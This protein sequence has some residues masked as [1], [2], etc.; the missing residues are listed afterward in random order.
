MR[1]D[2]DWQ[3]ALTWMILP[4]GRTWYRAVSKAFVDFGMSFST[5]APILAIA[6]LGE[7]LHQNIIADAIGVD[8]AALARSVDQLQSLGL[9]ERRMDLGDRRGRTLHL[10]E[11]GRSLAGELGV[12]AEN[13]QR[14]ALK[15]VKAADGKAAVRAMRCLERASDEILRA[16]EKR[17]E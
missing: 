4:V 10:T 6:K 7:G 16:K 1:S 12:V 17:E 9:V 2:E 5:A 8:T 14:Q 3:S 13:L 15:S 11:R